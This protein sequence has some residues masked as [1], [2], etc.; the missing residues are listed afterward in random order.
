MTEFAVIKNFLSSQPQ[1]DG[2]AL[3]KSLLQDTGINPKGS[4]GVSYLVEIVQIKK[5][6]GYF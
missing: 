6:H 2:W 1:L 4:S 5:M 3:I